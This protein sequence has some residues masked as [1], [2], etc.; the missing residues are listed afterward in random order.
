[1]RQTANRSP[2]SPLSVT[3]I[4]IFLPVG[5]IILTVRNMQRLGVLDQTQAWRMSVSA[6][7]I[8][9]V[10]LGIIFGLAPKNS[11]GFPMV[12]N[13]S[14]YA[15]SIAAAFVC[16]LA[17]REPFKE[18]RLRNA[19]ARSGPWLRAIAVGLLYTV[20]AGLLS[21]PVWFLS[22]SVLHTSM[23]ALAR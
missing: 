3:I 18:W 4:T 21:A 1:M 17:Q 7:L 6:I 16:Y 23:E 19:D 5:G 15:L 8:S 12:D 14:S 11:N 22:Q 13:S 20:L 9:A 2:W 10:G